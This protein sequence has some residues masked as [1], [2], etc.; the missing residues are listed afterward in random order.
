MS[1]TSQL[2]LGGERITGENIRSQNGEYMH[3]YVGT[4]HFQ[5]HLLLIYSDGSRIH[6]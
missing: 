2:L 5:L 6:C 3:N 1:T 4:M